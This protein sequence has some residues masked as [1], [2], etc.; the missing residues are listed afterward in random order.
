MIDS[1]SLYDLRD[2]LSNLHPSKGKA[3][4]TFNNENFLKVVFSTENGAFII[5]ELVANTSNMEEMDELMAYVKIN[6]ANL[7]NP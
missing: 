1:F 7:N 6:I 3:T 4:V 2:K 5:A